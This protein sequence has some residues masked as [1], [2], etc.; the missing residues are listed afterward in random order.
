MYASELG[1]EM[2]PELNPG[3][4]WMRVFRYPVERPSCWDTTEALQLLTT[5]FT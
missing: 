3:S 2:P 5:A 4:A 1:G